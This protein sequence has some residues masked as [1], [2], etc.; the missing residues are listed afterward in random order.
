MGAD[1]A[2]QEGAGGELEPAECWGVFGLD[3]AE[4]ED[5]SEVKATPEKQYGIRQLANWILDYADGLNIELSNMGL[6]KILFFA[7]EHSLIKYD[8]KLTNAKIEAWDHGPVFREV[9]RSFKQFGNRSITDRA[10][11]YDP[12][13]DSLK[14]ANTDIHKR[15]QEIIAEAIKD[16]IHLPAFVLR[17]LSHSN[18]GAWARVWY[19][20]EKSNPGMEISDEIIYRTNDSGRL[21]Q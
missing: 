1:P 8:R 11:V 7:Y 13:S 4:N 16:L 12:V 18:N 19:H 5:C 2:G 20:T 9:Y 10:S 15:D 17:E 21:S 14:I 6:N 3:A